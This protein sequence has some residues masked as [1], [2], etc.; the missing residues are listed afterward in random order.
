MRKCSKL[1]VLTLIAP[2][3]SLLGLQGCGREEEEEGAGGGGGSAGH[4]TAHPVGPRGAGAA[5]APDGEG[6][7]GKGGVGSDTSRGGT[8]RG[9]F[10]STG[11]SASS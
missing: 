8:S 2:G 5:V 7:Q 10:G 4:Y 1:I 9:G 3:L 6:G 11:R